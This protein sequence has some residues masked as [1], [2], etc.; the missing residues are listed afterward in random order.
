MTV[1]K[2]NIRCDVIAQN[3]SVLTLR[4]DK[5]DGN[6]A[7]QRSALGMSS[8]VSAVIEHV[9]SYYQNIGSRSDLPKSGLPGNQ[10]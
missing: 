4:E 9:M 1:R 3:R 5:L 10:V 8:P 6:E 2:K 7:G